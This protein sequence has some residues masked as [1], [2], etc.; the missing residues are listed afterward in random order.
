VWSPETV[1]VCA[2]TLLA[3][4]ESSFPPISFV[5]APPAAAS[6]AAEAFVRHGEARIYI[7]ASSGIV[8][9]A[10]GATVKCGE[11]DAVRKLASVLVHEEWHVRHGADEEGAYQAQL[12]AL[13]S[14]GAGPGTP[15]FLE[16]L[17]AQRAVRA[18]RGHGAERSGP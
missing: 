6:P 5:D 3:R 4:G 9:R 12:M 14:M 11:L 2:L 1:L 7:V 13:A 16:V 17:R 8:Q 15:V 10:R 18:R